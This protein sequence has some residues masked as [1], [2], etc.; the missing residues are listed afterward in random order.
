[1]KAMTIK[2]PW[3][4]AISHGPKRIENRTWERSFRGPLAIHAGKGWD[5]WGEE[6]PLV[7]EAWRKAGWDV[8]SLDP[9][10]HAMTLGAVVAL[11]DVVD[12]CS[13]SVGQSSWDD[14]L[15]CGCGKW[16]ARGQY[17][18]KLENV[19]PLAEPV[20][21]KGALGLWTLPAQVEAAVMA[22]LGERA[23]V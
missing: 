10:H 18:W 15:V 8:Y 3:S 12:I 6:S 9:N 1:M 20:P 16:A 7:W 19:R 4:W 21:C 5:Y 11:A 17:H 14:R 22:Q 13:K 23:D 2:P